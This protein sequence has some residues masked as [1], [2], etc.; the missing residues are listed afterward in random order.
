MWTPGKGGKGIGTPLFIPLPRQVE[1]MRCGKKYRLF[2]GAAMGA[3]SHGGRWWLYRLCLQIPGFEALILRETLGEIRRTHLRRMMQES[4]LLG[5]KP[6]TQSPPFELRFPNGSLIELGGMDDAE[7]VARYLSADYDAIL[8]DEAVKYHPEPLLELSTR[9]RTTKKAVLEALG[10][11]AVFAP[12]TN[13]GGPSH[14]MLL[15]LF[16]DHTPDYEVYPS[17]KGKYN[18]DRWTTIPATLEDNPYAP[19]DYEDD[20][21]VLNQTRYQQLRH[22]DWRAVS[23]QFFPHFSTA[24]HARRLTPPAGCDWVESMDW[25]YVSPGA[26][27]FFCHVGDNHWHCQKGFKFRGMEPPEVAA[28]VLATRKDLGYER[29]RYGVADPSIQSQQR[30]ESILE[31]FRRHGVHWQPALNRRSDTEKELGWPRLGSWFRPDPATGI[32]W[33]TFCPDGA[34]YLLRSIAGLL[35]DKRNPED[36]NTAM[37]D[38]GPDMARY[39]A[40]SRPPIDRAVFHVEQPPAN[41]PAAFLASLQAPSSK[42]GADLVRGVA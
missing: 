12:V 28:L 40:M 38:H 16:W 3:K 10:G 17:L 6:P 19:P 11:S 4:V 23:G 27:G 7:A 41:S 33:L 36:V 34:P 31:T 14:E 2:G 20:L 21:A 37:D 13:P 30:G 5:L 25:G 32:P 1:F 24:T 39:W 15:S 26:L 22:G 8:A 18:P 29:P 35:P 9:A 42:L